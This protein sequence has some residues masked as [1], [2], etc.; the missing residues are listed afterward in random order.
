MN[1][2][3]SLLREAT[4]AD[5]ERLDALFAHFDLADPAA[6]GHFLAAHAA[7]VSA[8]EPALDAAGMARLIPDWPARRRAALIRADLDALGIE[9]PVPLAPP[10]LAGDAA[11]WGAAYVIEGSRL[12]GAFLARQVG[13]GLPTAYLAAPQAKGAWRTFLQA[14]DEA[15]VSERQCAGATAAAR[16]TFEIFE[17]AGRRQLELREE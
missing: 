16:A 12:G 11:A 4:G 17:A 10:V 14:L 1:A 8:V 15:L 5:H 2:A 7:A 6:Y 9:P 13:A 3:R